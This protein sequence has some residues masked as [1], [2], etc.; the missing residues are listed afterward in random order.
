MT[1]RIAPPGLLHRR[2]VLPLCTA[3][4]G[5][6]NSISQRLKTVLFAKTSFKQS[7]TRP[8]ALGIVAA[9]GPTLGA[10][11]GDVLKEDAL[12]VIVSREE[13][14]ETLA[15]GERGAAAAV[16]VLRILVNF[17][18]GVRVVGRT[19]GVHLAVGEQLATSSIGHW[20]IA[21]AALEL[22]V[23]AKSFGGVAF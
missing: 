16:D 2:T 15:V 4:L 22:W 7:T 17:A 14:A 5:A 19:V 6:V 21:D 10:Q 13:V 11:L 18:V 1:G 23:I 12:F 3:R 9:Q 8:P 20:S